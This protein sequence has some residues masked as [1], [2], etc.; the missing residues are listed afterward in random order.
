[1][2]PKYCKIPVLVY[3][4]SYITSTIQGPW[5]AEQSLVRDLILRKTHTGYCVAVLA[6]VLAKAQTTSSVVGQA[7]RPD[8]TW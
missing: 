6:S 3:V 5:C 2:S 7:E 8:P 4:K 1:M